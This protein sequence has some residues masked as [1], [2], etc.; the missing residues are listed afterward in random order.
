MKKTRKQ[1][2]RLDEARRQAREAA[3]SMLRQATYQL[4]E[5][6]KTAAAFSAHGA[7]WLLGADV[8]PPPV[9]ANVGRRPRWAR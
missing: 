9:P 1:T 7:A 4:D 2:N 6:D 8:E 5:G 3:E